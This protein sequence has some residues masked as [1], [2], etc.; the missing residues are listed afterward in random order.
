MGVGQPAVVSS[1]VS[2][3]HAPAGSTHVSNEQTDVQLRWPQA[4]HGS[5]GAPGVHSPTS[6]AHDDHAPHARS[7]QV[8][9]RRPHRP[10][11]TARRS[12]DVE[13]A[14]PGLGAS[15]SSTTGTT[16]IRS[17]T[18]PGASSGPQ[19]GR[20]AASAHPATDATARTC[21]GQV[22]EE[23]EERKAIRQPGIAGRTEFDRG[24]ARNSSTSPT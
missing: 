20:G 1:V 11:R 17:V 6:L 18:V 5:G 8:V 2:G 16:P 22:R 7:S 13:H 3:V 4:P 9:S 21:D 24:P 14:S 15:P 10:H 19:S 23:E 12:P